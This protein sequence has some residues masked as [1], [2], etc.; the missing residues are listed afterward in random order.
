MGGECYRCVYHRSSSAKD[1]SSEA[2][3]PEQQAEAVLPELLSIAR[4]WWEP[5]PENERARWQVTL[6]EPV[7]A[8]EQDADVIS[9]KPPDKESISW[10]PLRVP[11]KLGKALGVGWKHRCY[12]QILDPRQAVADKLI[13]VLLAH[14]RELNLEQWQE[15]NVWADLRD[16]SDD[17]SRGSDWDTYENPYTGQRE[18]YD[19]TACDKECGYC[20]RCT[21]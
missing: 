13:A 15:D 19:Y 12:A 3:T 8:L 7:G 21:Y 1:E 18:E 6:R 17:Y 20:G 4:E 2:V 10:L 16:C 9:I 11:S 14:R 5:V